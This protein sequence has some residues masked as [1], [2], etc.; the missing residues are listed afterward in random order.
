MKKYF[1][2]LLSVAMLLVPL[3]YGDTKYERLLADVQA[4]NLSQLENDLRDPGYLT[5]EQYTELING[6]KSIHEKFQEKL[7]IFNDP[8]DYLR[9]FIGAPVCF[10]FALTCMYGA[11]INRKSVGDR[12]L[13]DQ[14]ITQDDKDAFSQGG[15]FVCGAISL[16]SGYA[17]LRGYHLAYGRKPVDNAH[18]IVQL[19]EKAR[20]AESETRASY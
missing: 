7:S 19:L 14:K 1:V 9:V 8:R 13:L 10:M 17:A 6:A 11:D 20:D 3:L 2:L 5:K 16:F 18:A 15:I 12:C 4:Q